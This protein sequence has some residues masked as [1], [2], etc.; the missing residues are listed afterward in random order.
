MIVLAL[1]VVGAGLYA[2]GLVRVRR[3]HRPFP[4]GSPLAFA[5]GLVTIGF[6]LA[7][8]IDGL[9]DASLS[10]HMAQHLA[11]M[12]IA[13]PLL[14]MGAPLRLALAALPAQ[15]A[16]A[17]ARLLGSAVMRFVDHPGFG[18]ALLTVVL[19]GT[20]FSPLYEKALENET[21]HAAEHALY[22]FSAL[23]YWSPIFAVAPAPHRRSHPARILSLFLSIPMTAFLGFI[24]YVTNRVMYPHYAGRPGALIDQMNAG[25]VMWLS[26][27]FPVLFALLWV[28]LDWA[29]HEQR[30]GA[31]YDRLAD[32]E[33]YGAEGIG[34]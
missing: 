9:A 5:L 3:A 11:L 16:R 29:H 31:A 30:L 21:I 23:V 28:V 2:W 24:F 12:S 4:P 32:R 13:A 17:L 33:E 10:W 8:P 15:R 18:L 14:L 6:A 26:A 27:G 1:L 19:Y 7:G 25:E 34:A 20:H 22:L